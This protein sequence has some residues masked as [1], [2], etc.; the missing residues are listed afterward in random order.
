MPPGCLDIS[1]AHSRAYE[2]Y[3]ESVYPGNENGFMAVKCTSLASL[4]RGYCPGKSY[5]MG[6]ACPMNLKGNLF[7]KTNSKCPYGLNSTNIDP[8]NLICN[9]KRNI[10]VRKDNE[11]ASKFKFF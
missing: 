2:Y 7:L 1:C 3:A 8:A 11:N 10:V 4:E 5:P 6:Y 9:D